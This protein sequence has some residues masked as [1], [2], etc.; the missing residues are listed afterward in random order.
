MMRSNR[1]EDFLQ[2][3]LNDPGGIKLPK[4]TNR[5]RHL[6]FWTFEI[7]KFSSIAVVTYYGTVK[8]VGLGYGK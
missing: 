5:R 1:L 8:N 3:T 4:Y 2:N 6:F 7:P